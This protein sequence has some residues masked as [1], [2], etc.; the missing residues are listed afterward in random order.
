MAYFFKPLKNAKRS[1][2]SR[3]RV[4]L[5]A[6]KKMPKSARATPAAITTAAAS[7]A[8]AAHAASTAAA[9]ASASRSSGRNSSGSRRRRDRQMVRD[10]EDEEDEISSS[11][12]DPLERMLAVSESESESDSESEPVSRGST[13]APPRTL[14]A[15]RFQLHQRFPGL[16]SEMIRQI[17][18]PRDYWHGNFETTGGTRVGASV[19]ALRQAARQ[20]MSTAPSAASS[21]RSPPTISEH[22]VPAQDRRPSTTYG[23]WIYGVDFKWRLVADVTPHQVEA[24]Q[25]ELVDAAQEEQAAAAASASAAATPAEGDTRGTKR[26]R[27]ET[28]KSVAATAAAAESTEDPPSLTLPECTYCCTDPAIM[29][30]IPCG[31]VA[32][33]KECYVTAKRYASIVACPICRSQSSV[34]PLELKGL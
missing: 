26:S 11:D 17:A 13:R 1:F 22:I 32:S 34:P 18:N 14:D 16:P 12:S 23:R 33:C 25:N 20:T 7:A 21:L 3:H 15:W 10:E 24:I 8:A 4:L 31:H 28:P 27:S 9:S 30:W 19:Q 5:A 6:Q 2:G 29:A